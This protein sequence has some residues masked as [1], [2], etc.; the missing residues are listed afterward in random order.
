[1]LEKI[2]RYIISRWYI[3]RNEKKYKY[4]GKTIK[5]IFDKQDSNDLIVV[6]NAFPGANR[7]G[8]YN[9]IWTLKDIHANKLF[10]LDDFGPNQRG[11]YY[12]GENRNFYIEKLVMH[13]LEKIQAQFKFKKKVF[14]GSSKGGYAALYFGIKTYASHIICG[15]PQFYLGDY[16]ANNTNHM[17][18]LNYIMGDCSEESVVYLNALLKNIIKKNNR[19]VFLYLHYSKLEHTYKEHIHDLIEICEGNNVNIYHDVKDYKN[20]S[21]VSKYFPKYIKESLNQIL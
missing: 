20:H 11:S 21:D 15:A 5:Y 12:L 13:L 1:M 4:N 14:I 7:K 10:I 2:Y 3:F 9:Y 19:K 18:I 6:F 17:D 8:K 16:L